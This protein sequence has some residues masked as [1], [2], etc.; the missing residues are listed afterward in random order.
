MSP[1][2]L[3]IYIFGLFFSVTKAQSKKTDHQ[4]LLW[5]RYYNIVNISSKWSIHSEFDNRVFLNPIKENLYVFRLQGRY[6]INNH[7]ETGM[8][9]AYFSVYTQNPNINF[10]FEI[11]EYRVQQDITY[12]FD[13]NE[14]V[15]NQRLQIEERFIHNSTGIE[16]FP[17]TT[18]YW[19]FR[20]RFQLEYPL[21]EKE[22]QQLKA[23]LNDEI[24]FNGGKHVANNTFDQNRIYAALQYGLNKSFSIELGYLHSYQKRASGIDYYDR[25]I[26]RFTI[27]H[28]INLTKKQ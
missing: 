2:I 25:N 13:L 17:S 19:R 12:K 5:T 15:L 28:K 22:T 4:D 16:L 14:M 27:F 26:I 18:F 21:W 10:D 11:P 1:K 23:I 3:F 9:F 24:M 8:G 20:Y 6:K 7:L